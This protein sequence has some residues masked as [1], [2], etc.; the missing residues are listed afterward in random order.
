MTGPRVVIVGNG[1]AGS[2]IAEEIR[3]RDPHRLVELTVVGA[4]PHDAYNRVLLSE[5]LAGRH[6]S[7]DIRLTTEGWHA[8]NGVTIRAGIPATAID[9]DRR[10]VT[11][12]DDSEVAYDVLVLATGSQPFIPTVEGL[13]QHGDLLPGAFAFRTLDDCAAIDVAAVDA[14]R[15]VVL[16]GG[17]L[18]VEAARG[19]A[20]R[21]LPVVVVH[22]ADHLMERQLDVQA[23]R[24]LARSLAEH[25]INIRAAAKT[26]S[27]ITDT[28]GRFGG[29]ILDDGSCVLGDLLVVSAGVRP[30]VELARNAGIEVNN[31]VVVDNSMRSIT[32]PRIFAI[33]E[34][35]EHRSTVYG[36]VA[37]AWEQAMIAAAHITGTGPSQEYLGSRMVTR[38]KAAGI[39]LVSL[40]DVHADS[41]DLDVVQVADPGR[42]TY[43]KV[44]L[45]DDRIVG[46]VV[47]GDVA[48]VG[49]LTN[50]FD[51][52]AA[53][54][55]DR[56]ALLM[57]VDASM[58]AVTKAASPSTMPSSAVVCK[59]NGVTKATIQGCVLAG[60]T[61]VEAVASSTRATTGCGGCAD[62]VAGIVEWLVASEPSTTE[63]QEVRQPLE[64]S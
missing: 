29:L 56:L 51:R 47:L 38:L 21:G 12:G 15:A 48:G 46:A 42:G 34:C 44:L 40:G 53:M 23:G 36:L 13:L 22:L 19:L 27:V 25:G 8:D 30:D 62:A 50:L 32:D 61:S 17:L 7:D 26:S 52:D 24:V 20:A 60:S 59:C 54:P 58:P 35:A 10:I 3:A 39:N 45:R 16:G 43:A 33:G 64:V 63:S 4:E 31:G 11:L 2:R 6:R 18:G 49:A 14:K 37:P 57:P 55:F 9:R 1:M 41:D 28:N 5:V